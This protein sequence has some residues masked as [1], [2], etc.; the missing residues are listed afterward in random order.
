MD[1]ILTGQELAQLV[2]AK[3]PSLR[4]AARALGAEPSQL[5]RWSTGRVE[6]SLRTQLR[7]AKAAGGDEKRVATP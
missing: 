4:A 5:S 1:S 3:H 2:I 7:L 6:P